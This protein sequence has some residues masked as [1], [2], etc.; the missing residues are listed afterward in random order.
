LWLSVVAGLPLE[1]GF[2]AIGPAL[3]TL[4]SLV[5][6]G[7]IR[8]I[9]LQTI[10]PWQLL[11]LA[12]LPFLGQA[13]DTWG[14]RTGL[15]VFAPLFVVGAAILLSSTYGVD[16]DIRAAKAASLAEQ[17]ERQ[18]RTR[19]RR[20]LVICRDVDVAYDSAQVLFHVDVDVD[21]GEAVA[22]LGT[23]GAGKSSLLHAIA[24][25]H[26]AAN[27]AIFVDG[28][29]VTH[30]PADEIARRG[31]ALVPSDRG[32]FADLTVADN[33]R[34]A[35]RNSAEAPAATD[36][37]AWVHDLFPV[38]RQRA[39]QPAGELSGGEQRMLVLAQALVQRPRLLLVDELS[40][41]LAPSMVDELIAALQR[42]NATGTTVVCV[43]QSPTVAS[44][45]ADR[46]VFLDHGEVRYD[47]PVAG[48]EARPDL[49]RSVLLTRA[50][51][52]RLGAGGDQ[53]RARRPAV[54]ASERP[55]T[56]AAHA[57]GQPR[58]RV[59][60]LTVRF[61]GVQA[62]D[63]AHLQLGGHEVIGLIG[64]NGAGKTT[65]LDAISGF[66]TPDDGTIVLDGDDLAGVPPDTRARRG[67]GRSFQHA[68]LFPALTVRECV[69]VALERHLTTRSAV[70]AAVG[71][72][73]VRR[74][75]R[76]TRRRA[77]E[78]IGVMGLTA[79]A[80]K[81][82]SELSMGLR[83]TVDL[84]CA[85][86]AEPRV[87]LLDEPSAGLAHAEAVELAPLITRL[88]RE[89]GCGVVLADH[90]LEVVT[91]VA[92][93]L[94]ALELGQV[95][96]SGPPGQVLDEAA[97]RTASVAAVDVDADAH[98]PAGPGLAATREVQ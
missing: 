46:A 41:G 45:L 24:G 48:L 55:A 63:G 93:R 87:L 51:A 11:G 81:R 78:L 37:I 49:L 73:R 70:G 76:A 12:A 92:T 96:A 67:L 82:I 83:R 57:G 47:G 64:P 17:H 19:G 58:L 33:L 79:A 95:V 66:V 69:A 36:A 74:A 68:R 89:T 9:G 60:D 8:G 39:S 86:A 97:M 20:K 34:V 27:G 5:V 29:D 72:Q 30:A 77:H 44:R 98:G 21:E 52:G 22:V 90:D 56:P 18:A 84:A 71:S 65:L 16:R 26:E 91:A 54:R 28:H 15:L 7:R 42:V 6:P 80:D 4:I 94:V 50:P 59:A 35:H 75:E 88:V 31:V 23:N 2:V 3:H 85:M 38:L 53:P 43:D 61:G 62:L 10:A 40:L 14:L 25:V 13:A 1:F 32:V